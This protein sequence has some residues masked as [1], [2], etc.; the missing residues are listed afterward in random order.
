M[1]YIEGFE[2]VLRCRMNN[3]WL[4]KAEGSLIHGLNLTLSL[5]RLVN[6]LPPL[7]AWILVARPRE[8]LIKPILLPL[9][10]SAML[11]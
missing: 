10:I 5:I 4:E 2:Q 3:S 1:F 11:T 7:R 9:Q 6:N 8:G